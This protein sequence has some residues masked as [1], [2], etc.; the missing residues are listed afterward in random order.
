VGLPYSTTFK[1]TTPSAH[2]VDSRRPKQAETPTAHSDKNVTARKA[3]HQDAAQPRKVTLERIVCDDDYHHCYVAGGGSGLYLEFWMRSMERVLSKLEFKIEILSRPD[4]VAEFVEQAQRAADTEKRALGFLP[5]QAFKQAADQGKLLVAVVMRSKR[6]TYGGHL[7]HGGVFPYAKIFQVFTL[8]KFRSRGIGRRL[9]EEIVRRAETHQFMSVLAQVADDLGAN[10]FWERLGFELIRKKLGGRTTGRQINVRI[11]ELNTL[12]LF[13]LAT[14]DAT[15]PED[16]KLISRFFDVSPTYL[17]DI[18]ILF[19]LVKKRANLDEVGRIVRASFNNLVRLAIADE[20]IRELERTSVPNPNDPILEFALRLPRL[21]KPPSESIKNI[22]EDLGKLIFPDQVSHGTLRQ[23]DLSDLVHL[24]TAIYHQASGFVTGEKAILRA[25]TLLQTKYSIDVV[26]AE[27]L[28]ET[29]EPSY[30]SETQS[31]QA[32]FEGQMLQ[33][34]IVPDDDQCQISEFLDRMGCPRQLVQ[35][36]ARNDPG[37][38]HRKLI[39]TCEGAVVAFGSW[40]IPS[41]VRPH[42]QVFLCVDED[43][44]AVTLAVE[45]LLDSASK[46]SLYD[47]PVQS[48]LRLL[49]GHVITRRLAISHGFRPAANEAS[50]TTLQKVS[51]GQSVTSK[52]WVN[53]RQQLKTGMNLELPDSMPTFQSIRQTF[54]IRTPTG[55]IVHLSLLELETLLSPALFILTGRVGAIVPIRRVYAADLIGGGRQLQLL[56]GPEAVLLRER[57][58]F[59]HP[60][61]AGVFTKGIPVVFYESARAGGCASA[62][63]VARVA[64]VEI[65]SKNSA[66]TELLRR[67]VIDRKILKNIC[68]ADTVVATTIDSIMTFRAPVRLERLRSMGAVDGA[69]LVTA[70]PLRAERLVQILEEGML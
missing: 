17:L 34:K 59:S 4:D 28:A 21:Q 54:A 53:V 60:R 27:E 56:A 29:V 51:L 6:R 1:A 24:T 13:G 46:E 22:V 7:L 36:A 70:R 32:L 8:P 18:N 16:L 44:R 31:I 33:G 25:R 12:Q 40:D 9:V 58:Y 30:S 26:G 47:Y 38:P 62:I 5:D 3:L 65:V 68:L 37:R 14:T 15:S 64:R 50:S 10:R 63:A 57:T 41:A 43:H 52:N 20:F 49:P 67:G 11:R 48:S 55:Q 39:V 69:N 66:S 35:D 19:D 45:F 61:T 2:S 42:L 23:Q